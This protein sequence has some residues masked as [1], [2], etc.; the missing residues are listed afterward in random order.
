[1]SAFLCVNLSVLMYVYVSCMYLCE[2]ECKYACTHGRAHRPIPANRE[3]ACFCFSDNTG[4]GAGVKELRPSLALLR[5]LCGPVLGAW[6]L[7]VLLLPDCASNDELPYMR[8]VWWYTCMHVCISGYEFVSDCLSAC[9]IFGVICILGVY[10]VHPQVISADTRV[11]RT[12]TWLNVALDV[13]EGGRLRLPSLAPPL[14]LEL[15]VGIQIYVY[16]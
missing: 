5:P 8:Q 4:S 2:F 14:E 13:L 16:M 3:F 10:G 9:L 15:K 7:S 6:P 11:L 1:M 12:C